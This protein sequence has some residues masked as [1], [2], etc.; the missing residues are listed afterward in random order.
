M[1]DELLNGEEF[2]TLTEA[3]VVIADWINRYNNQRPHR[4]LGMMTP[5]QYAADWKKNESRK[6]EQTPSL[7]ADQ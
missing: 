1:R 2:E 5:L 6:R 4:G 7:P 3:R